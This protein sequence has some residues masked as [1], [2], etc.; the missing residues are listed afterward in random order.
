MLAHLRG[1]VDGDV[2]DQS[3]CRLLANPVGNALVEGGV[4]RDVLGER[5]GHGLALCVLD[6]K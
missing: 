3:L 1:P 2:G 4:D 5:V 6:P